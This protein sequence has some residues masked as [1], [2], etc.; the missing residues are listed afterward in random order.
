MR[1]S[2]VREKLVQSVEK[3]VAD[4]TGK[5]NAHVRHVGLSAWSAG[6]GAVGEIYRYQIDRRPQIKD[7]FIEAGR[8][9]EVELGLK[10]S[11]S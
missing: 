10:A 1:L 3:A 8:G 2:N 4:K 7:F 9:R 11:K 6:Y 5:K